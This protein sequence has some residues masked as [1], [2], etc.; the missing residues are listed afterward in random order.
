[1]LDNV[2]LDNWKADSPAKISIDPP[3]VFDDQT[4]PERFNPF[5][6]TSLSVVARVFEVLNSG[7]AA[8]RSGRIGEAVE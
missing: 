7:S 2:A 8:Q 4:P 3:P 6:T 5:N 1:M